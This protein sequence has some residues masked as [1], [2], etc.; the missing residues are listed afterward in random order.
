MSRPIPRSLG[1]DPYLFGAINSVAMALVVH[2][3]VSGTRFSREEMAGLT[4]KLPASSHVD[5]TPLGVSFYRWMQDY[6]EELDDLLEDGADFESATC[7]PAQEHAVAGEWWATFERQIEA[8]WTEQARQRKPVLV[9]NGQKIWASQF[10]GA[11]DVAY[12]LAYL[13]AVS[14]GLTR[15]EVLK[16]AENARDRARTWRPNEVVVNATLAGLVTSRN[17]VIRWQK[18]PAMIGQ[19]TVKDKEGLL[20][21]MRNLY[22]RANGERPHIAAVGKAI[23]GL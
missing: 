21:T 22:R 8:H 23:A 17:T 18:A 1:E 10:T 19:M 2:K 14:M 3:L 4:R 16:V 7:T 11:G 12:N 9:E 20:A 15:P 13:K 5:G 6:R